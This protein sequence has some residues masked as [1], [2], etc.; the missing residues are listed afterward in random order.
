MGY[1][2]STLPKEYDYGYEEEKHSFLQCLLDILNKTDYSN[3]SVEVL[4]ISYRNFCVSVFNAK[5][6]LFK[7]RLIFY[8]MLLEVIHIIRKSKLSVKRVIDLYED[9]LLIES[10]TFFMDQI[11]ENSF[12]EKYIEMYLSYAKETE[13]YYS[14]IIY[15]YRVNREYVKNN[16][17]VNMVDMNAKTLYFSITSGYLKY[18]EYYSESYKRIIL[19]CRECLRKIDVIP[20]NIYNPYFILIRLYHDGYISDVS[21]ISDILS[22]D[23]SLLMEKD[24]TYWG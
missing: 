8:N 16:Y 19:L 1:Y 13:H 21:E 6:K 2:F 14:C 7:R 22:Y 5:I 9:I 3:E 18:V 12:S 20:W 15:M 4:K 24:T 17:S 23:I 10:L 11:W